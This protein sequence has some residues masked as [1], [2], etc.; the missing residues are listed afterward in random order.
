MKIGIFSSIAAGFLSNLLRT[1]DSQYPKVTIELADGHPSDHA[2]AIRQ[3]E[4]D[5]AF[6]MGKEPW[7]ECEVEPLWSERAVVVLPESH[8]LAKKKQV[9]WSDLAQETF[10]VNDSAPGREIQNYLVQRLAR[11]GY[12][13]EIQVH[14]VGR[15]N[16]LNLVGFG[17]G[18]T[19][20]SE[21]TTAIR[22]PGIT[23]RPLADE[24]LLFSAVWSPRNS[25][26]AFRRFLSM[27][28]SLARSSLTRMDRV[29]PLVG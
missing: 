21:A 22:I 13:P 15:D 14:L 1:Y 2:A 3:G 19:V 6:L 28:K 5:I 25:N 16:L 7:S 17:Y 27:A 20:T 23:Y 24:V 29:N 26:P 12:H 8:H 4:L 9:D 10:L 18:L 11:R